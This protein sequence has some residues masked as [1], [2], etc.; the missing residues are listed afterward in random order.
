MDFIDS[1]P[2][3]RT[4]MG[5]FS[6]NP[7]V[8]AAA[9]ANLEILAD[10]GESGYEELYRRG[11]RLTAGLEEILTDAGF[12]VFKPEFAGFFC[13]NFHDGETDPETWTE[14]RHV[15]AHVD[16]GPIKEFA[17]GLINQRIFVPPQTIRINLVHA[18]T[19]KQVDVMLDAAKVSA[20]RLAGDRQ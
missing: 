12:D 9:K 2:D 11:E 20:A 1:E 19:N 3:G 18:H 16:A 17:A 13:L 6:G 5:T 8:V 10:M 7:L 15:D 4:F 14:Y